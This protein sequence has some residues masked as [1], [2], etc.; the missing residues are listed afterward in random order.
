[1]VQAATADLGQKKTRVYKEVSVDASYY[2][3]ANLQEL[4]FLGVEAF[5]SPDKV[6][7]SEWR[8][9]K[10]PRDRMPKTHSQAK[11]AA[12]TKD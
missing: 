6:K 8:T 11:D 5:I 9:A 4:A 2:S 10:N 3:E 12:Q 7:H 1:M